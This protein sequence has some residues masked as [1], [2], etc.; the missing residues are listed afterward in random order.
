MELALA[1]VIGFLLAANLGLT[2]LFARQ[3]RQLLNI[4]LSKS[5]GEFRTLES[6]RPVVKRVQPEQTPLLSDPLV[7]QI[8]ESV[9]DEPAP[10]PVGLNGDI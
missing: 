1:A 5:V 2:V 4:A 10:M 8:Y 7:R 6:T 3:H 9:S